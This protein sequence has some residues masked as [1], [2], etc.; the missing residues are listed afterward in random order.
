V[1]SETEEDIEY[2]NHGDSDE[3]E[4][5]EKGADKSTKKKQD[6]HHISGKT[7]LESDI[8]TLRFKMRRL[9][10]CG[11]DVSEA[12]DEE[13][14]QEDT[15]DDNRTMTVSSSSSSYLP[16][17]ELTVGKLPEEKTSE[18]KNRDRDLIPSIHSPYTLDFYPEHWW[19]IILFSSGP[20]SP[21]QIRGFKRIVD[22]QITLER[23]FLFQV[24]P[25]QGDYNFIF[26]LVPEGYVGLTFDFPF[27]L[28]V[29]SKDLLPKYKIHERDQQLSKEPTMFEQIAND[30]VE[31]RD[32]DDS[33]EEVADSDNEDGEQGSTTAQHTENRSTNKQKSKINKKKNASKKGKSNKKANKKK[34]VVGFEDDDEDDVEIEDVSEDESS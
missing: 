7:I 10:V 31:N 33:D 16:P 15:N 30:L 26:R 6:E 4:E 14:K 18:E 32:E 5:E 19:A 9:H 1:H 12:S 34:V 22:Q 20:N 2:G 28:K 25:Q 21:P 11:S 24:P 29:L 13:V 8:V 27:S 17:L 3:D 23:E